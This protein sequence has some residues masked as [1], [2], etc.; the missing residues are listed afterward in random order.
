MNLKGQSHE[1]FECSFF[2]K[3]APPGPLGRFHFLPKIYRDIEQK[4]GSAVYDTQQNGDSTVFEKLR[5]GFSGVYLTQRICPHKV[6]LKFRGVS[7]NA[8]LQL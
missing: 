4:V 5:N 1:I 7:Y 2:I 3:K 8:E 6:F